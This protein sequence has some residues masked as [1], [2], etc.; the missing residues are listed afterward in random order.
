MEETAVPPEQNQNEIIQ[1]VEM[2]LVAVEEALKR[3]DNNPGEID[4]MKLDHLQ[5]LL[6]NVGALIQSIRDKS[7][8]QAERKGPTLMEQLWEHQQSEGIPSSGTGID[9]ESLSLDDPLGQ[10]G[11][12]IEKVLEGTIETRKA[13]SLPSGTIVIAGDSSLPSQDS[14]ILPLEEERRLH[15]VKEAITI[16]DSLMAKIMLNAGKENG[17]NGVHGDERNTRQFILDRQQVSKRI[18]ENIIDVVYTF[19]LQELGSKIP[20]GTYTVQVLEAKDIVS[21]ASNISIGFIRF[22][23]LDQDEQPIRD[24]TIPPK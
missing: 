12:K 8:R 3:V 9:V 11:T 15:L 1:D 2:T 20:R 23:C 7:L 4:R 13:V 14:S 16:A 5:K 24:F 10:V 22:V 19:I 6:Q 18:Q 21:T 17:Q